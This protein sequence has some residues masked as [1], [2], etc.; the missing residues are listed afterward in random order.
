MVGDFQER[1]LMRR[2]PLL[3]LLLCVPAHAATYYA[4]SSGTATTGCTS[5]NCSP[6]PCCKPSELLDGAGDA[7]CG[8]TVV[9]EDGIY[10]GTGYMVL[11]PAGAFAC[12]S[13]TE[14]TISA[15]ND[16][17][18]IINGEFSRNPIHIINNNYIIVEGFNA[19][20]GTNYVCRGDPDSDN[21]I[22]RRLVGWDTKDMNSA[23]FSI[24]GDN[25]LFEDTA[26]F[27][28]A[29]KIYSF[30]GGNNTTCRRCWGR[31]EASTN[32]GPKL[33][34]TMWYNNTGTVCENCVMTW[35]NGS[36]PSTYNL[37][38]NGA[39]I[40]GP[41]SGCTGL[42]Q[43]Y[44][45]IARDQY[46]GVD[47]MNAQVYGSIAYVYG[48]TS[49]TYNCFDASTTWFLGLKDDVQLLDV[50]AYV[51][52]SNSNWDSRFPFRLANG[53]DGTALS[54]TDAS[55]VGVA[56]DSIHGDW[57]QTDVDHASTVGGLT[58]TI[59]DGT[60][61][62]EICYEYVD[63]SKAAANALWPWPMDDRIA[64]ATDSSETWQ[65]GHASHS[66]KL[67]T[68]CDGST[69]NQESVND[70]HAAM[71]SVTDTMTTIFGALPAACSD[72]VPPP[73]ECGNDIIEGAE[74]CDGPTLTED[75]TD[76]GFT[77]GVLLCN[78]SCDGYIT[79]QCTNSCL[80]ITIG[81]TIEGLTVD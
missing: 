51:D 27:G 63:G 38:N 29:R 31:W 77:C 20:S 47:D 18:V 78:E 41:H 25:N 52:P 15:E 17:G 44:G 46:S 19:H 2:L 28:V 36:M 57:V 35:D 65:A 11:V 71:A 73:A 1:Q 69:C 60:T 26:G 30:Q 5:A 81:V 3:V 9:F 10:T 12:G 61:G 40:S 48:A 43:A 42:D 13:G 6:N 80:T 7:S 45:V 79:S 76:Q 16:G 56:A 62:A 32:Q 14:L 39:Q 68:D 37:Q 21:L 59:W 72:D 58:D 64:D 70:P 66:H 22:F 4:S 55:S 49:G 74:L 24:Q 33:A 50:V 23:V 53:A 67:A 8:D 34:I 54:I 75:C